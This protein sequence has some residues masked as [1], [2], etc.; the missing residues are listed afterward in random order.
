LRYTL[1]VGHPIHIGRAWPGSKTPKLKSI[2][3]CYDRPHVV[4]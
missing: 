4:A 2:P 1:L 3:C